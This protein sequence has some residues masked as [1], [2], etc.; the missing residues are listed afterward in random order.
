MFVG[1]CQNSSSAITITKNSDVG[2]GE[3]L[4]VDAT[5]YDDGENSQDEDE[6]DDEVTISCLLVCWC[7]S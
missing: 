3:V 7:F 1:C 5:E 4:N 6:G 2:A